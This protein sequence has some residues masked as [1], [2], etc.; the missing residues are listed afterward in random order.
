[1]KAEGGQG[2][3]VG[4]AR[5]MGAGVSQW[6]SVHTDPSV[7]RRLGPG[8]TPETDAFRGVDVCVS[9]LQNKKEKIHQNSCDLDSWSGSW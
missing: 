7:L 9:A 4:M 1:M 3:D 8:I 5:E 2:S 6:P